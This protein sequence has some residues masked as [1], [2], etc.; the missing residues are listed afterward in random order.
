MRFLSHCRPDGFAMLEV[1]IACLVIVS[2]VLAA[3]QL[4][5]RAL[6][7]ARS[8]LYRTA[9]VYLVDDLAEG[10]RAN[11]AA[12]VAYLV[13]SDA[14]AISCTGACAPVT[15]AAADL[16]RWRAAVRDSMAGP[17]IP[18]VAGAAAAGASETARFRIQVLWREPDSGEPL[19][20]TSD[21]VL[22]PRSGLP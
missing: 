2:G 22:A 12:G 16:A 20:A 18:S 4:M 8:A 21:L 1:L 17:A 6:T 7:Q 14:T 5:V 3:S 9:A 13:A 15:I 10:I 19:T 11:A